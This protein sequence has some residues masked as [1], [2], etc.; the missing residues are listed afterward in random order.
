MLTRTASGQIS[1]FIIDSSDD[2]PLPAAVVS[3]KNG[4]T[5]ADSAGKFTLELSHFPVIITVTHM[6]YKPA[7]IELNTSTSELRIGLSPDVTRLQE[8][9]VSASEFRQKLGSIP[10]SVSVI[11][12]D[13]YVSSDI[14]RISEQLNK[15]PG[16]FMQSGALNT[17]R[18]VMRGSGSRSPYSTNRVKIYFEDIPITSG[19]G[20]T[21]IED[22][23]LQSTGRIEILKGPASSIFGSGLGGVINI[24]MDKSLPGKWI[25]STS[26]STGSFG[27]L[28]TS[29]RFGIDFGRTSVFAGY[30]L[31]KSDGY[32]ENS[33]YLRH[34]A[35][36]LA[37]I[38][39]NKAAVK[40]FIYTINLNAFIP[41]SLDKITYMNDPA[42][43]A[44]NWLDVK[45]HE[46][47]RKTFTGASLTK[48]IG[49]FLVGHASVYTTMFDQYEHR[50]FN[51]LNDNSLSGG[52]RARI[53]FEKKR[54]R[55]SAGT[56]MFYES[57][58][59]KIFET[60]HIQKG[61]FLDGNTESRSYL[62]L[63]AHM[64][65]ELW[66]GGSIV[67][68]LSLNQVEYQFSKYFPDS[69]KV[70]R[71]HK[72]K[73]ILSP[74]IGL[75]QQFAIP[76]SVYALISHGFSAPSPEETLNP[77]GIIN[78]SIKPETGINLEFG[79]R[80]SLAGNA[81]HY[82]L[83]V[84]RIIV[85]NLLVTKRIDEEIF[86][87]INAGKTRHLGLELSAGTILYK[88]RSAANTTISVF[89][90][91]TF[92]SNR[93]ID[94]AD[95]TSRYDGRNLPGIPSAVVNSGVNYSRSKGLNLFIQ[96][97]YVSKMF[98]DDG[99]T[100]ST[101][102]YSLL[103]IKVMYV[104]KMMYAG[105]LELFARVSN[106]LGSHYASMILVNAKA[107]GSQ[108]PRY[109]YPGLPANYTLGITFRL[110]K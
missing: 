50:P 71:S 107:F 38:K 84:Y 93:F 100:G 36:F 40:V 94:F 54:I 35:Y 90:A 77:E 83:S 86:T 14:N 108:E 29:E 70:S 55:V 110:Q 82:E 8:V 6:G 62:S 45:G 32:R 67:C 9:Y 47:Y 97:Q 79:S 31:L 92:S 74:R 101:D 5:V 64:K 53:N 19:E 30:T 98:L 11:A 66:P 28:N 109:Y 87:G 2:K 69:L 33:D 4:V 7:S 23:D 46:S 1:G 3:A 16:V 78:T 10:A 17:N 43:A 58:R 105:K 65:N 89:L 51:V 61:M 91:S 72:F 12:K 24:S 39:L 75:M 26:N 37:R 59:W 96:H 85:N 57:Y 104:F 34:S 22:I 88:S 15:I 41:S 52:I 103:N 60:E 102:P 42:A 80:G 49:S 76:V 48:R 56:E 21:T 20:V 13:E 63:F 44:Q 106:I 18:L 25:A 95:D 68:G 27:L 99:N 73:P 81:F